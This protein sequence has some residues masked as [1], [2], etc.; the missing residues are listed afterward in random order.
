VYQYVLSEKAGRIG[1]LTLNRPQALN[2]W[3]IEMKDELVTVLGDFEADPD[4]RAIVITGA[5]RAFCAGHDLTR[6]VEDLDKPALREQDTVC[7]RAIVRALYG[8]EKPIVAQVNGPA[9]GGGCMLAL[10][11]DFIVASDK[12]TFGLRYTKVGMVPVEAS[13]FWLTRLVGVMKAKEMLIRGKIIDAAEAERIGLIYQVTPADRLGPEAT[14]LA[15][16]LADMPANVV[17]LSKRLIHR[18][19]S[20][21][22]ELTLVYENEL[23]SLLLHTEDRREAVNSI[24]EKRNPKFVGR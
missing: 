12:A 21:D 15:Q 19:L 8:I 10:L 5:G 9:M 13:A 6:L 2:S 3:F 20:L 24:R 16:E 1:R 11:C 22:L 4:V 18:A 17:G 23:N 14:K 7:D